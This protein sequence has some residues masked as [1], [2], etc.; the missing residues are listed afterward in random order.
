MAQAIRALRRAGCKAVYVDGS[1]AT[2][3]EIPGDYAALW[4]ERGV[5]V[6][7]LDPTFLDFRFARKAQKEKYLGEWFPMHQSADP[8]G[9]LFIEFFQ[10]DRGNQPKG[11]IRMDLEVWDDN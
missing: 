9:T 3:K 7:E 10:L 8:Y 1:F 11:I 6:K 4:D 5:D 2:R